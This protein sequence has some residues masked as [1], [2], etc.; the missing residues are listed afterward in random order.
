MN[1]ES[2][3]NRAV[4]CINIEPSKQEG[5]QEVKYKLCNSLQL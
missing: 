5:L 1:N 4:T 3:P 2:A